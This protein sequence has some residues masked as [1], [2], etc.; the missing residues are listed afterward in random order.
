MAD[1]LTANFGFVKPELSIAGW[2]PKYHASLDAVDTVL[3]SQADALA[4]TNVLG[5]QT[6]WV[7]AGA[8]MPTVSN[9]CS[10]LNTVELTAGRPD[11]QVIDFDA[12]V[13]EFAQF[14]YAMPKAWDKGTIK[15]QVIWTGGTAEVN[16]VVW[17]LEAVAVAD[18]DLIDAPYGAQVSVVDTFKNA[19]NKLAASDVSADLTIAGAPGDNEVCVFRLGRDAAN[20]ADTYSVDARLKGIKLYYS[21]NKGNDV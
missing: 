6:L 1:E 9:G 3:K 20:V 19:A 4:A 14:D 18:D 2:G 12:D 15:F 8:M 13:A 17:T 5:L 10:L 16:D 21:V 7:P 11:L